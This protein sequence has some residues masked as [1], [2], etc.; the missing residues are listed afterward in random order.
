[1]SDSLRPTEELEINRHNPYHCV[2]LSIDGNGATEQA[3]VTAKTALPQAVTQQDYSVFAKLPLL[4]QKVT[5]QSRLYPKQREKP[6]LDAGPRDSFWLTP[7]QDKKGLHR[8]SS[9]PDEALILI[10]DVQ[11]IWG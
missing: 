1:S 11:V 3:R 4:R 7:A 10:P 8:E 9:H 6:G 5:A 2:A